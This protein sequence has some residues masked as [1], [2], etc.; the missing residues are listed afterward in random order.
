MIF[1]EVKEEY[2]NWLCGFVTDKLLPQDLSYSALFEQLH[3][4]EFTYILDMD[5][6]RAMDGIGLRYRF[7]LDSNYPK[8]YERYLSGPCSILEVMVALA[9]RCEENIMDD[10]TKGNRTSQ[11]FWGMINSL[12][13]NGMYNSNYDEMKVSDILDTFLKREYEP[14]GKGGLFTIKRTKEDLTQVEIWYQLCW[15]L[16]C[17]MGY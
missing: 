14:N 13:L 5:E 4:T 2:F 12:G 6:N 16:D 7:I 9:L 3:S 11:W 1:K 15:Y 10:P 8:S 17:L